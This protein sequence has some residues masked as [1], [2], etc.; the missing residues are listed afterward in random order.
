MFNVIAIKVVKG[1]AVHTYK[2]SFGRLEDASEHAK[3]GNVV[4]NAPDAIGD[5][6]VSFIV[7]KGDPEEII[8][9]YNCIVPT[10]EVFF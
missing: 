6:R 7:V 10:P 1:I 8:E 3:L 2:G 5:D 4:Y 9:F